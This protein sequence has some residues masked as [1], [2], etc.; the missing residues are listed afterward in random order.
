MRHFASVWKTFFLEDHPLQDLLF[1]MMRSRGVHILD[2]FPCF[3]TTAHGDVEIRRIVDAF[4]FG[5]IGSTR[6]DQRARLDPV[7]AADDHTFVEDRGGLQHQHII[8]GAVE[9]G[10]AAENDRGE[11]GDAGGERQTRGLHVLDM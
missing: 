7:E 6:N 9:F 3:L 2:N 11:G 10:S 5:Y 8:G 4:D 1:A